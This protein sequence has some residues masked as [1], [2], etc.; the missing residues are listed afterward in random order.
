MTTSESI[1]HV[2]VIVVADGET[3]TYDIPKADEFR[4][5]MYREP[6]RT[7]DTLTYGPLESSA[8]PR[9]KALTF[10]MRPFPAGKD[11]WGM[12]ITTNTQARL[13]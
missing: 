12:T 8:T 7:Y 2:T 5:E 11:E 13:A 10:S 4:V 1:A 9:V 6:P 3:T